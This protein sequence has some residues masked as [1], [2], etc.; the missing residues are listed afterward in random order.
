MDIGSVGRIHQADHGV[1]DVARK[2]HTLVEFGCEALKLRNDRD[3]RCCLR[4]FAE[5]DPDVSLD[6][7]DWIALDADPTGFGAL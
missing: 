2:D 7:F 5:E 6:L 1:V 3:R 4:M